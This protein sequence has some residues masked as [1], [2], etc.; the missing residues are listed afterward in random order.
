VAEASGFP[1]LRRYPLDGHEVSLIALGVGTALALLLANAPSHRVL[2]EI[3]GV[4]ILYS[5]VIAWSASRGKFRVR[6]LGSYAFVVWYYCAVARITPALGMPL[7]DGP[8]LG[9]DEAIFGQTPAILCGR[10]ATA[11]FSDVMSVCYL[12]YHVYLC[13]AVAHAALVA[14]KAGRMLSTYLFTGFTVGFVGYVLMPAVG[15]A[16]A[17]P[18]LFRGP[19]PGGMATRWTAELVAAGSS[20]YD[21]FPSLHILIT[22]IL[23]DHDFRHVRGRFW[24]MAIPSSG[25]LIS[26]IYLRYHYGVDVFAAFVLFLLLRT[27]FLKAR[28][29][30][31]TLAERSEAM[32]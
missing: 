5:A 31:V 12:T 4:S 17:F 32:I 8:L 7:R 18:D 21:V 27:T 1:V 28:R 16:Q 11:W 14:N 3:T 19:L 20:G 26:T 6:F 25:L 29:R 2:I 13:M 30:E 9:I 23:L 22:C 15:P 10:M 24:M